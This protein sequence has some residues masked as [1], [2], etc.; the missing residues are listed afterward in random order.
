MIPTIE[1]YLH[2]EGTT[3]E[4]IIRAPET[5][6]VREVLDL[7]KKAGFNVDGNTFLFI[8]D[9]EEHLHIDSLLSDCGVKNKHHLNCHQCR[10]IEVS[11]NFNGQVKTRKFAPSR[12][13]KRVLKWAVEEFGLHGVDAENKELR[14]GSAA[15]T[16]LQ[17][18]QHIGSF[19]NK[20]NCSLDLFLTAIVEVQ[21]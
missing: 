9:A 12:K 16:I 10:N 4:K 14:V 13:A 20:R 6:T 2:G 18:Q 21:G 8:E 19:V 3:E 1:I 17:S 5:A 7:A 11:V 15:G